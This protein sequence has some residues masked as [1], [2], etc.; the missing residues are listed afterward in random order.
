MKTTVSLGDVQ[1]GIVPKIVAVVGGDAE[2]CKK[3]A[4]EAKTQRADIV[5]FR[6]DLCDEKIHGQPAACAEQVKCVRAASGLPILLTIRLPSQGGCFLGSE[7]K[8]LEL[9]TALLPEVDAIDIELSAS[10]IREKVVK[11]ARDHTKTVIVSYHNAFRTPPTDASTGES[12]NL[13]AV[14]TAAREASADIVKM[15]VKALSKE[16]VRALLLFTASMVDKGA[17]LATISGGV[18]GTVSRILNPFVGSC[19]TYGHVGNATIVPG[20]LPVQYLRQIFDRFTDQSQLAPAQAAA[21][22]DLAAQHGWYPQAVA[23]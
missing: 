13:E 9:F 4:A 11:A 18:I 8:R 15:S 23:A 16:D 19:L 3:Q 6:L 5:E 22:I 1:V 20:I 21:Y 12:E 7:E 17:R 14:V 2:V 10:L